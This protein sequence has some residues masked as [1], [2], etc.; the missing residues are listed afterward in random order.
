MVD[1]NFQILL[2]K[3]MLVSGDV[4]YNY[5]YVIQLPWSPNWENI[6][7]VLLFYKFMDLALSSKVYN[8]VLLL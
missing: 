1:I 6:G 5:M 4:L 3:P 7:L 8:K 2:P